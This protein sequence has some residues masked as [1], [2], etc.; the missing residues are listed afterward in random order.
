MK[1]CRDTPDFLK[2]GHKYLALYRKASVR[3][4]V[5]GDINSPHNTQYLCIVDSDIPQQHT[6][7]T[8]LRFN[9]NNGYA[10]APQY[11][12]IR[13]LPILFCS[14]IIPNFI[15]MAN[16]MSSSNRTPNADATTSLFHTPQTTFL[17]TTCAPFTTVCRTLH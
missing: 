4:T 2:I 14:T 5:A 13:T 12:V 15:V 9:C 6:Q 3:F 11:Y 7:N 1:V 10:N 16:S 17:N 8:L